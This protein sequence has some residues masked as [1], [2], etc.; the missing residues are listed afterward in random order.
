MSER[1]RVLVTNAEERSML[2]TCRSLHGAGYDVTA[3]SSTVLAAAQWSRSC[4]RHLRTVDARDDAERFVEQLR[5]EL[6]RHSYATLIAGSDSSLLAI[7]RQ[8]ERIEPLTNLGLPSPSIVERAM[9]RE[10]LADAAERVGMPSAM[11]IRCENVKQA[12][13]A[14]ARLG[15]PVAVKSVDAA[16]PGAQAIHSAPKGQVVATAAELHTAAAQFEGDM[17]LQRWVAGDVISFGGVFAEKHML[18]MAMSRY[19]RMWPPESGS[20]TFSATISPPAGLLAAVTKLMIVIGWEGIFELELIQS[21]PGTFVPIDLNPRPYGSMALA[22]ATGVPLA[23]IWCDWLLGRRTRPAGAS[24]QETDTLVAR[25]DVRYRWE[26]GDL[27]N[28]LAQLRRGRYR[29]ALAVLRPH[30]RVTHALFQLT[31]PL[32]LLARMLYLG[33]RLVGSS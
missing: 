15:F 13:A 8:R 21:E 26:D 10:F 17:L 27:R 6:T 30:R 3:T 7:S 9:H 2:A 32:P 23:A 4:T 33:K 24:K 16:S 18:G 14:A 12:V 25:A 20:V 22:T 11:S 31:D 28:F 29:A 5:E 1:V 19:R